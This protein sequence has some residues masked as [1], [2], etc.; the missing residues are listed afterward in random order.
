MGH[1][2]HITVLALLFTFIFNINF[3]IMSWSLILYTA[4]HFEYEKHSQVC[5]ITAFVNKNYVYA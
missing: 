3:F 5:A 2:F 1:N 4:Y